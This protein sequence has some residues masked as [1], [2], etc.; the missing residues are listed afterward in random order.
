MKRRKIGRE[1]E[2]RL[3][4]GSRRRRESTGRSAGGG[5]AKE[6]DVSIEGLDASKA[7]IAPPRDSLLSSET[8]SAENSEEGKGEGSRCRQRKAREARI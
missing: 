1:K 5:D 7:K 8:S 4:E 3:D 2:R 6:Y